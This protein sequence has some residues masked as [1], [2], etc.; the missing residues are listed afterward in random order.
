MLVT[1]NAATGHFFPLAPTVRALLAAGHDVRVGCPATFADSVTAAGFR[2]LAC[3]EE[4]VEL[5]VPPP[6]P[7]EDRDGRLRWAVTAGWPSDAPLWVNDLLLQASSWKPEV[8][9]V[10]PVEHA[11]RI[12]A[13]VLG[14]PVVEHG[15][16]FTL[17]FIVDAEAPGV[18]DD[19]YA[20]LGARP[21]EPALRVDLGTASVQA[22]DAR[23][24]DR[25]RY[26][27]WSRPGESTPE[28]DGR[29]RVLATLGTYGYAGAARHLQEAV[30][31]AVDCGAQVVA[32]LGNLDGG[33]APDFPDGVKVVNWVD[34]PDE[35]SRSDVVVHHGGAGTSWATLSAGRPALVLPQ[36]GDQFSNARELV[37]V[38]AAHSIEP[39]ELSGSAVR[40]S[41]EEL[42]T[43]PAAT[44]RAQAVAAE[45]AA[46]PG[47]Q[48]LAA[49]I[50]SIAADA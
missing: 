18:L 46:L 47:P 49:A 3:A 43:N 13:A 44:L 39:V 6:P 37:R 11:G 9:V 22:A 27:A 28:R 7:A 10:E 14:L 21:R 12:V 38:G 4:P 8:V 35:I 33:T 36:G 2:A 30:A 15:W 17:P 32:V 24:V 19:V 40:R 5:V 50:A 16:G 45:N 42:L 48:E 31:G 29:P 23:L 25:Y 20:A 34:L 26:V 1:T 41:L